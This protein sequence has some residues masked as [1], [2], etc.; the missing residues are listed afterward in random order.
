MEE[1][2]EAWGSPNVKFIYLLKV[3]SEKEKSSNVLHISKI[4]TCSNQRKDNMLQISKSM[5]ELILNT[6]HYVCDDVSYIRTL[7]IIIKKYVF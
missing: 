4:L 2:K 6:K 3:G 1:D 7:G 5:L